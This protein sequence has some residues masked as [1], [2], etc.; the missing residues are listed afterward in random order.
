[1]GWILTAPRTLAGADVPARAG[2]PVNGAAVFWAAGCAAC[3]SAP[4]AEGTDRLVLAGGRAFASD[5]GTFYAPNISPDIGMG[6]GA[7]SERDFLNAVMRGVSPGGRHY[8]PAFPYGSYAR[9]RVADMQDLWA[10]LQT[11]PADATP[12]R[13]HEVGFPFSIRR[14]LGAWKW[15]Y[16]SDGWVMDGDLTPELTRGR[17]LVEALGHCTECH[18]SRTLLGGLRRD[19]WLMGAPNPSGDGRIPDI[20][21]ARLTWSGAEITNYLRDGF[22]PDFDV[23]SG[24]M[25]EVVGSLSNLPDADR[26]AIAAYLQALP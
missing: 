18:T 24:S 7:W 4:G 5:F 2:D 8:Y 26:A 22:T 6:L 23:V 14:A 21:P 9:A 16:Q 11:L 10:Y 19:Q 3:H 25:V 20:T 12:S 15:L 17:Y 1:L 13:A